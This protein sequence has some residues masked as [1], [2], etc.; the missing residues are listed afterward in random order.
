MQTDNHR[1]LSNHVQLKD[2]ADQTLRPQVLKEFIGQDQIKKSLNI[3][4]QAARHRKE[5][6]DHILLYGPPGLGK[7][8]LAHIIANET[9]SYIQ[10][11]SGP[12]IERA[13]DLVAVLT[14]LEQ[15]NILFIDEIHRLNK[16][17]EEVLY[18][19]ME[20]FKIDL[21]VGKGPSART[22]KLDL[23]KFS[24]IGATTRLSLVSSPLRDRFGIIYHFKFYNDAHIQTI[25]QRSAKILQV[26]IDDKA[27]KFLAARS[28]K[29]PRIANRLLKR[30]R[31]FCQV[32]ADGCITID[33]SEQALEMLEIDDFGLD[34]LD[35]RIL[36]VII[37]QFKGGPV[38]LNTIAAAISEEE[39]TIAE[40][41]EPFLMQMGFL[42][43][44]SRGRVATEPAYKHL[45][46]EMPQGRL[47]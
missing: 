42:A 19:A 21:I 33:L 46:V 38:G 35:R 14:N 22:L 34:E 45:E 18:G 27:A 36:K 17:I 40:V 6:L 24:L 8:T 47:W 16:T 25:I 23:P 20:D 7:T 12:A 11:T 29:T 2:F 37:E 43:R 44:T 5:P 30:V 13:G 3:A 1:L 4:I 10:A 32:K 15:G 39:E 31:D 41:Y 28:R 26:E 9:N